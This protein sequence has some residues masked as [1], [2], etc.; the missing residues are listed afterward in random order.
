MQGGDLF[1]SIPSG[2]VVRQGGDLFLST[3]SGRV[4]RQGDLFS[5]PPLVE[6]LDKVVITQRSSFS[7]L[8]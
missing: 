3:P 2:R 5:P 7:C 1:L 4:V 8:S 6:L